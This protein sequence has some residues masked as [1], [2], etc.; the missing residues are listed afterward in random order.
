MNPDNEPTALS[1]TL[2]NTETLQLAEIHSLDAFYTP[3]E[4]RFE[5]ITRLG[6]R[7][8]GI[9]VI[10]VTAVTLETQWFKSVSGWTVS[11]LPIKDSLCER[12]VRKGKKIVIPDLT[13]HLKY[14]NHPLVSGAPR[15]RFYAGVPLLNVKGTVIG[16]L[17]AMDIKAKQLQKSGHQVLSDLAVLAQRELL[18]VALHNAQTELIS[19]LSIARRQA[20]LDPLTRVWNRRG[21]MKLLEGTLEQAKKEQKSIAV[22]V[23]DVNDFKVVNDSFGHAVGD[24]ALRMVARELLACVRDTDGVCRYGGDEFFVV[25]ID[26]SRDEIEQIARRIAQRIQENIVSVQD[27]SNTHV[28]VCIGISFAAPGDTTSAE[29]MLADADKKLYEEKMQS[30]LKIDDRI[31]T[32]PA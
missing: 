31:L 1:R 11:E 8:L 19:K 15:F 10:G 13:K 26:A 25:I 23:V 30:Q 32:S 17:C 29:T 18:T 24:R 4:E 2:A 12:T 16:T 28:S 22:C 5:R 21:G 6:R 27:G 7:A 3:I 9:P 20:M 14:T